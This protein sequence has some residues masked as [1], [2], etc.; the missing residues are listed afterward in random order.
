LY[1]DDAG[2][3]LQRK[4]FLMALLRIFMFALI[5]TNGILLSDGVLLSDG[6]LIGDDGSGLDPHGVRASSDAGIG[7]DPEGRQ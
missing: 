4:E 2:S 6:L 7:L 3:T 5:V 1:C